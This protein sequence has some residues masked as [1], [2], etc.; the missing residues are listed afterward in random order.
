MTKFV[1]FARDRHELLKSQVP[2]NAGECVF[3]GD[4]LDLIPFGTKT[5]FA[6]LITPAIFQPNISTNLLLLLYFVY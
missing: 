6:E 4:S 5:D 1:S 3:E 2:V